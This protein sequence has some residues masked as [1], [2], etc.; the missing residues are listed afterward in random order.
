M[1]HTL[2]PSAGKGKITGRKVDVIQK[3]NILGMKHEKLAELSP[4]FGVI[5][6][7]TWVVVHGAHHK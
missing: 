6:S 5:R 1:L 3:T 7:Q 2:G 4:N